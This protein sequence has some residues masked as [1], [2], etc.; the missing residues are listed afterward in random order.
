MV[1]LEGG[2]FLMGTDSDLAWQSDAEG[3]VRE[4]VLSPFWVAECAVTNSQFQQFF[5]ATG[6]ITEAENFGWSYVFHR[7]VTG[8]A[9]KA[10]RGVAGGT[11]WWIG[12]DGACWNKPEGPGSNIR[13]RDDY[14]V[15]HISWND[16]EAYCNWAEKRLPTE[17]EWE[18]AARGG[19]AQKIYPWGDDLTP[20]GKNGKP[21]HM[22]NIWQG[23]FPDF[24]RGDDG[25][26]NT[27]PV[28][29]FPP[30]GYGLYNTS[31][32]AWE[33]CSDGWS[34]QWENTPRENPQG[35][36]NDDRKVIRGGSFLCHASY[37]TRYRVAA[38][39]ANTPD[40]TTAHCG[41]RVAM[42][43]Y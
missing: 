7:H 4:I 2:A 31:G 41:F 19:L 6:Y 25:F 40:S 17:A 20:K 28:K 22:C 35:A 36:K 29:S 39:T 5:D 30:N 9:R 24:D 12:V 16:A 14:P 21:Q 26:T 33:W 18:Y 23:K 3:P 27:A 1:R 15:V 11:A 38:R 34:T 37:C 10:S 43:D 32:N 13:K 42:N 8:A